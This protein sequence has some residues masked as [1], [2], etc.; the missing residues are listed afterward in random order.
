MDA[1]AFRQRAFARLARLDV[2]QHLR[3]EFGEYAYGAMLPLV[4]DAQMLGCAR[5]AS[6][7]TC[8]SAA[9]PTGVITNRP[10]R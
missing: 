5:Q 9:G 6:Q 3:S 1:Q 2:G 10:W 8:Y 7:I 4:C